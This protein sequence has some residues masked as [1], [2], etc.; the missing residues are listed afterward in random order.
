LPIEREF[1]CP[2]CRTG[3]GK[4][5]GTDWVRDA[6][7]YQCQNCLLVFTVTREAKTVTSTPMPDLTLFVFLGGPFDG[8]RLEVPTDGSYPT[9]FILHDRADV[10]LFDYPQVETWKIGIYKRDTEKIDHSENGNSGRP[11]DLPVYRWVGWAAK[12]EKP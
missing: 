3:T 7:D 4:Y 9:A 2:G 11:C 5:L 1:S 10:V 12:L 6:L 8:G